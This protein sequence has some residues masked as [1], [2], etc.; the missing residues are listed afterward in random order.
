MQA[1]NADFYESY[2][3]KLNGLTDPAEIEKVLATADEASKEKMK[4]LKE[5][6]TAAQQE[7]A[8]NLEAASSKAD[9]A[10]LAA[11]ESQIENL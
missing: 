1:F 8:K 4:K 7:L 10:A 3:L 2:D 9:A 6:L 11:L 5:D